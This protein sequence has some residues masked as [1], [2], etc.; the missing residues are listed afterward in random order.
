[1][2]VGRRACLGGLETAMV[3]VGKLAVGQAGYYT[4]AGEL[5]A[6]LV[7]PYG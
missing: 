6:V 3:S 4:E 5:Q 1:M 2:R 7:V